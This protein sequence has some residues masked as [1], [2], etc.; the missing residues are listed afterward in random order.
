MSLGGRGGVVGVEQPATDMVQTTPEQTRREPRWTPRLRAFG[1]GLVHA[2]LMAL[3]FPPFG[4]WGMAF[5]AAAPLF[6]LASRPVVS[7]ASAGFW[8]SL[9]ASAFWVWTHQWV[10]AVSAAGVFPLVIYLS[11][12]TLAFVWL[13]GRVCRRWPAWG[14]V[15]M[16]VIW[17]GLEFL[18]GRVVFTGYPWYLVGHPLIDSYGQALAQPASVIG[19]YGVGLLAVLPAGL[20]VG[21]RRT[22]WGGRLAAAGVVGWV[23][24]SGVAATA[25]PG[26][27]TVRVAVVQSNIP[28][29]NR[30]AWTL[31]QRYRDWLRLRDLTLEA[32]RAEPAPELIVWPEGLFPGFTLDPESLRIE[33]DA[34]A[35]WPMQ[36]QGPDD[37]PELS[38]VPEAIGATTIA[39]ELLALQRAIGI[40]MVVGASG[41]AGL[42]LV[43]APDGS[44]AYERDAV[45][46]SAMVVEGGRVSA[47]RYDKL[48]LTPFGEVMPYI[49]AWG[50]LERRLLAIGARGMSFALSPGRSAVVL[51]ADDG[52]L[53]VASP[54]CYEATQSRV[55]RRLV[56]EGGA[57]RAD[58]LV[59]LTNDGWFGD[60][61]PGRVAHL[62]SARWRCVELRTPMIRAANTG[63]SA[64]IDRRGRVVIDTVAGGGRD[65]VDGVV[66]GPVATGSGVSAFARVGDLAGWAILVL[67]AVLAGSTWRRAGDASEPGA[68]T[69]D[70]GTG[71]RADRRRASGPARPAGPA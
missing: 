48:L 51:E 61:T 6:W 35:V 33:R 32:A 70:K 53:R 3:A 7:L 49:S 62:L 47:M 71:D 29:D 18:R 9:G 40:P 59:N 44:V 43:E 8:A 52:R 41:Y 16:P 11:A 66:A 63:V 64:V 54:I 34:G 5:V 20:L 23:A 26:S 25:G 56:F 67:A 13:G 10:A 69:E 50:W 1:L 42:R 14:V 30:M 21:P 60:W 68:S 58:L 19:A 31:R 15:G 24:W 4:L 55:C 37:V 22:G 2:V 46:N 39:D 57:R 38:G 36:P 27:G 17:V 65:R 12:Y 45:Y 28:Q